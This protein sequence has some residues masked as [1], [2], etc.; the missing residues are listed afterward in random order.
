MVLSGISLEARTELIVV[1]NGTI[2]PSRYNE[3]VLVETAIPL[4][5]FIGD[6]PLLMSDN[7]RLDGVFPSE[8]R[9]K[10]V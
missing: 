7:A 9:R 3:E 10:S 2:T 4:P 6:Q 1:E 5:P 8:I